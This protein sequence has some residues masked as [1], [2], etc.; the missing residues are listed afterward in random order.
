MATLIPI[1]IIFSIF[2]EQIASIYTDDKLLA[3]HSVPALFVVY[4]SS[5]MMAVAMIYFEFVSGT[6]RTTFALLIETGVLVF[7][8]AYIYLA[9]EL[10][11]FSIQFVWT[12]DWVYS[13]LLMVGS[14]AFMKWYPWKYKDLKGN[15][16][17]I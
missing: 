16:K 15:N 8:M 10:L 4:I 1:L 3:A 5:I 6:G 7:Y 2:P 11:H 14:V 12:A 13:F 17:T 9:T